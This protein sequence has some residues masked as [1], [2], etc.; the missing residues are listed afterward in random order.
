MGAGSISM[1]PGWAPV[2]SSLSWES[3]Q[4]QQ[5]GLTQAPFTLLLLPRVSEHVR[6]CV[7]PLRVESI[8]HSHMALLKV[9]SAGLQSQ[10]FWGLY[11]QPRTPGLGDS[12]V[13][14]RPLASWV[15]ENL[16]N[17]NYPSV[18]RVAHLSVLLVLTM[19]WLYPAPICFTMVPSLYL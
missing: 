17:P 1:S 2:A 5:V 6:F 15:G 8:S 14:L 3:L 18:C 16:F 10:M 19:L 7:H 4:D 9:S 12:E 13:G 11:S